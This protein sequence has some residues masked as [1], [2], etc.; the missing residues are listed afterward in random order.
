MTT[1]P[2][3]ADDW[4]GLAAVAERLRDDRAR[5]DP[6]QVNAGRVTQAQADDRARIAQ[7]LA[8]QWRAIV[9]RE[10]VPWLDAHPAEILADLAAAST[11]A[12]RRAAER[13]N[14]Q[15][16]LGAALVPY[17]RFAQG[18]AALLWQQ[19]PYRDGTHMPRIVF[20]H[21]LRQLMQAE[22]AAKSAA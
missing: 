9:R 12:A 15:V 19:Q 4:E 21:T 20:I 5:G 16:Q 8:L 10:P 11:A 6:E 7:A 1:D 18:I 22:R 3:F 2:P 13:P 17:P 14:D